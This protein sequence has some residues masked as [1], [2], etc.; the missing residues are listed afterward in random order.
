MLYIIRRCGVLYCESE[1]IGRGNLFHRKNIHFRKL[2]A[3]LALRL[4]FASLL[5]RKLDQVSHLPTLKLL[6]NSGF[7]QYVQVLLKYI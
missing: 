5:R 7:I 1:G 6:S 3:L 2:V 4:G